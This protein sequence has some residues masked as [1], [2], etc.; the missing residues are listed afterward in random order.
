MPK[1][2]IWLTM[3]VVSTHTLSVI[4]RMDASIWKSSLFIPR[5][6]GKKKQPRIKFAAQTHASWIVTSCVHS[7]FSV[8]LFFSF[9]FPTSKWVIDPLSAWA[10]ILL[11]Y[12]FLFFYRLPREASF[13]IKIELDSIYLQCGCSSPS[14]LLFIMCIDAIESD[15]S[16]STASYSLDMDSLF[17][18][19]LMDLILIAPY[20]HIRR[21]T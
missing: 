3:F 16:S 6:V 2:F 15:P 20:I 9:L 10:L 21:L 12:D 17:T 1:I 14:V 19:F 18:L 7:L 4:V 11:F 8:A 13:S 5:W